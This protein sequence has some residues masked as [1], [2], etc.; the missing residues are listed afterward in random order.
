VNDLEKILADFTI[1]A[2]QDG[3]IVYKRDRLGNKIKTG[4]ILNPFDPVVATL[5]D[6][7]SILSKVYVSEID[8]NKIK[9]GLPV[10]ITVD[11]YQGRTYTGYISSIANIG[12]QLPNSDSKVFEVLAS[13]KDLDPMLRPTMTTNNKVIIKTFDNILYI[14]LESLHAD[15]DNIPFVYTRDKTKQVVIPGEANDKF[16]IIEKGLAEGTPVFLNIPENHN[17]FA[18][19][20]KELIAEIID[21][22]KAR[23]S[24]SESQN[25]ILAEGINGT[26]QSERQTAYSH[27]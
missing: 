15:A 25:K 10:R 21:R 9:P 16:V 23:K 26:D 2:P 18:L 20:G 5:P 19:S 4:T 27:Q 14:P 12:E 6:L 22:A 11:A 1:N 13:F 8:I 7:T 24:G 17:K 3:M